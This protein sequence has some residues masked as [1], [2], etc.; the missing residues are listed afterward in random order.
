MLDIIDGL[1]RSHLVIRGHNAVLTRSSRGLLRSPKVIRGLLRSYA[2]SRHHTR[3]TR[4][5]A[6]LSRSSCGHSR[7][8]AVIRGLMRSYAV[9]R[10]LTRSHALIRGLM[11]SHAILRGLM[12][13]HAILRGLMRSFAVSRDLTRSL[14]ILRGLSRSHK[15]PTRHSLRS[16]PLSVAAMRPPSPSLASSSCGLGKPRSSST[17]FALTIKQEPDTWVVSLDILNLF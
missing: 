2:V 13:S 10:D 7:S 12:R 6:V 3:L 1:S 15:V 17:C 16:L 11:R 5:Y 4:S 14:A 8:H 9:S